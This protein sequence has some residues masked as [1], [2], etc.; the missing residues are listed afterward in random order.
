MSTDLV[1][2]NLSVDK[3]SNTTKNNIMSSFAAKLLIVDYLLLVLAYGGFYRSIFAN[4]DTLWGALDPSST[5]KARLDC[6][7]WIPGIVEWFIN[8]TGFLPALHARLSLVLFICALCVSLLLLQIVFIDLFGRICDFQE[9]NVGLQIGIVAAVSLS[10][11][12]V[13]FSEFFYFP[14]SYYIF[15]LAFLFLSSGFYLLS[16]KRIILAMF[17]FFCMTMCYQMSCPIATIII[18]VYVYLEHKGEFSVS[19]IKEELVKA[20]PPMILFVL[21]YL[22]GPFIQGILSRFGIESYQEKSAIMGY[23][24]GEYISIIASSVGNLLSSN[25]GLTPGIYA[26]LLVF[27]ISLVLVVMVCIKKHNLGQLATFFL[28]EVILIILVLA[29]QIASDPVTFIARTITTLY[30]AQGM[31]LLIMLYF[32]VDGKEHNIHFVSFEKV[33]YL[34]PA[35]YVIFQLFFI[36]C[37]I[38]NRMVSE[39]LDSVYAEKIFE[40]IEA[41]EQ[42]TGIIVKKIAPINDTDSSPFYDQVHF[43]SG[44]INRRC[45]SDYTWTFLQ[46]CAYETDLAGSLYGRSFERV[47]MDD[48]VY[49]EL[50]EGKNWTSFDVDDQVIIRGDTVYICVF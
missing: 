11:V 5:F 3:N 45:Y 22:T 17:S 32:I 8:L 34:L 16:K 46:Y 28:V 30:V 26:P 40:K 23:G 21:N 47:N 19:L 44:A 14:E 24:L 1:E 25:L 31:Q 7:R 20:L 12:N 18:G 15:G 42:E 10:Y 2:T 50:F 41:Y 33:L 4:S 38:Q 49:K 39:T 36:Q 48:D 43:C 6:F 13:L 37:I 29:V 35:I 9:D 27:V